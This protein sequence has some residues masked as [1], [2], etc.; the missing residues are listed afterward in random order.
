MARLRKDMTVF[1]IVAMP[2]STKLQK[3]HAR[4]AV[5]PAT[6]TTSTSMSL[7]DFLQILLWCAIAQG[8]FQDSEA[9]TVVQTEACRLTY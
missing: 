8:K 2:A 4:E 3:P 1:G 9:I 7:P 6:G 5:M